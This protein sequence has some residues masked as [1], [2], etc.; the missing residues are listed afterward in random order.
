M[1]IIND[2]LQLV[3]IYCLFAY[4]KTGHLTCNTVAGF[5]NR[6][7]FL[8]QLPS[9][10]NYILTDIKTWLQEDELMA[11]NMTALSSKPVYVPFC[12]ILD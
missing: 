9:Y 1:L 5:L 7:I 4:T 8:Q 6:W 3:I 10:Q 2:M 12:T 11:E